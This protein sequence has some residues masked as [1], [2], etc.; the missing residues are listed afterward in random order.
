MRYAPPR[1]CNRGAGSARLLACHADVALLLTVA[2]AGGDTGRVPAELL[3]ACSWKYSA[4]STFP[5]RQS[6]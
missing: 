6:L 1:C 2:T 4:K 3:W 5:I